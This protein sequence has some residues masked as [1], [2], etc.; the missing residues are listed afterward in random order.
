MGPGPA[1]A[2]QGPGPMGLCTCP[3]HA[4]QPLSQ[5]S[6]ESKH[7]AKLPEESSFPKAEGANVTVLGATA[8]EQTGREQSAGI[9]KFL[10]Y[11]H[12]IYPFIKV[13]RNRCYCMLLDCNVI[14]TY[15]P[16]K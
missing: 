3:S 5:S 12:A 14:P 8:K 15:D 7:A 6:I 16:S 4:S 9:D 11:G 13:A 1:V 10:V 2:R